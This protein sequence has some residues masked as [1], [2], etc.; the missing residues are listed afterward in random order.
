V[1]ATAIRAAD[2]EGTAL[3]LLDF[4]RWT[5]AHAALDRAE[6]LQSNSDAVTMQGREK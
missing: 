6:F 1:I 3:G 5:R 2:A 4:P